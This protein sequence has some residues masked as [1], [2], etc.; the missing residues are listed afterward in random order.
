MKESM[1]KAIYRNL[2]KRKKLIRKLKDVPCADCDRRFPH[3][4]MDFDHRDP[5]QKIFNLAAYVG[6]GVRK[7]M[8]E[9]AKCDVVCSNCH[10]IRTWKHR[11]TSS[12]S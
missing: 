1:K 10:R 5:E 9:A 4:V 8:E 3:Y 7:I 12:D 11:D 2:E 6:Y